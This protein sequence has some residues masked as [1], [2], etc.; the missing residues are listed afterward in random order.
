MFGLFV[1][2]ANVSLAEASWSGQT[3]G[4]S[5]GCSFVAKFFDQVFWS[6]NGFRSCNGNSVFSR[7]LILKEVS[8]LNGIVQII[9]ISVCKQF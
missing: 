7:D 2:W 5:W 8:E 9:V 6:K 1:C 4:Q 3:L